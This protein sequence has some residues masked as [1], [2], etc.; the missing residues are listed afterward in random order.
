[1]FLF[2]FER[3]RERQSMSQGGPERQGGSLLSL[4]VLTA[5]SPRRGRKRERESQAGSALSAQSLT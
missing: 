3:E 5:V 2:I 1:M 4:T